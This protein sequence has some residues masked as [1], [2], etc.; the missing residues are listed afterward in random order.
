VTWAFWPTSRNLLT[1]ARNTRLAW[2]LVRR[3][4]PRVVLTT[5]AA[6]AVPFAWVG[7]LFGAKVVYVESITRIDGPS[8]SCRLIAPVAS[9]VYVQWPE[10]Q[11]S[12]RKARYAGTVLSR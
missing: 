11:A 6:T 7:R 12:V 1:L 3:T 8:L 4:R 10:L 9:R 2:L 5:G